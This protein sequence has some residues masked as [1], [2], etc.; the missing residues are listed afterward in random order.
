MFRPGLEWPVT[1]KDPGLNAER[2]NSHMDGYGRTRLPAGWAATC[3]G[4][5]QLL[6]ED[7]WCRLGFEGLAGLCTGLLG[8]GGTNKLY[9]RFFPGRIRKWY[10]GIF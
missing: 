8:A 2:T 6:P 10:P 4:R 1:G 9:D 7:N 5:Y 3:T